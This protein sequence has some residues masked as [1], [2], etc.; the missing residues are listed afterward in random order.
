MVEEWTD[1][2]PIC[3]IKLSAESESALLA[4]KENHAYICAMFKEGAGEG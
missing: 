4:L 1:T 2:C 3:N